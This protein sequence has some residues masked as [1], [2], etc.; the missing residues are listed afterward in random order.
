MIL[1]FPHA[2]TI[3]GV[4]EN[5]IEV[6]HDLKAVYVCGVNKD[7]EAVMWASGKLEHL[8]FASVA[9]QEL[10]NRYIRGEILTEY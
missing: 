5:V 8:C 10:A 9:F 6:S 7:G 2:P 3:S 1:K 4:L